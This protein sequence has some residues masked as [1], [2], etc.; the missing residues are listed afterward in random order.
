MMKSTLPPPARLI[1]LVLADAADAESAAIPEQFTPSLSELAQYSGLNRATVARHLND[2]EASGWVVR[3]RPDVADA[4]ANGAKTCYRLAIGSGRTVPPPVVVEN[5]QEGSR[6]G[7]LVAQNDQQGSRTQRLPVVAENDNGS[8][9]VRPN[10]NS[11]TESSTHPSPLFPSAA[12]TPPRPRTKR[13]TRI[14]EN[15]TVTKPM[16]AWAEANTPDVDGRTETERFVDYWT[17]KA[18]ASATKVDWVATW[19]NWLRTAQDRLNE[20]K[21]RRSNLALASGSD[22]GSDDFWDRAEKRAQLKEQG[23]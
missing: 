14:P 15:F 11:L 23:Q 5:N 19:R 21:P 2:L 7:R 9:T 17:A 16:V 3:V 6:T 20:R 4:R 10:K 8:R 18:G 22:I 12:T 13:G 1:M